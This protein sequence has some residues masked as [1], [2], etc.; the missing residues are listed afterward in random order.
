MIG[1]SWWHRPVQI[2]NE[3]PQRLPSSLQ[4]AVAAV[5]GRGPLLESLK[6]SQGIS[7]T[8]P[9]IVRCDTRKPLACHGGA[10]TG[11]WLS[12]ALR[13][14]D[15]ASGLTCPRRL[16]AAGRHDDVHNCLDASRAPSAIALN[17]AQAISGST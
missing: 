5:S 13:N 7:P 16:D 9:S 10:C 2:G 8:D 6:Q 15:G 3:R 1:T 14:P 17:L 12:P 11:S 4:P